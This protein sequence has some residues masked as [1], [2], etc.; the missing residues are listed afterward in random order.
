MKELIA[1]IH[2][3]TL[4]SGHAYGTIREMAQAAGG[5][6]LK[7]LGLSEHAPG[8]PGTVDPFYYLNL[9]VIPRE[10]FGVKILHGC[11]INVLSGGRLSLEQ[12]FINCLDYAIVGIHRQC[13]QDEG[14]QRNT[15]N[16]IECMKHEKVRLVSH[17]DDDHTP[18]DYELLVKAAKEY[19][20]ALEVNNSSLLKPHRRLNCV[21]N[22]HTML[23]LCQ[24]Y[25]TNI[26]VSSDAH[27]PAWVG[28]WDKALQLLE[29]VG[30]NEELIVNNSE[31]KLKAFLGCR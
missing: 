3:H 8:I 19:Q 23:K 29:E 30:F 22:Y 4:A 28:E 17:P 26:I 1:D 21:E 13:Y 24:K 27:D 25:G 9:K 10:L 7:I 12:K 14:K 5:K 16:L 18:L 20:V 31:E 11:E 15:E 2:T 6:G